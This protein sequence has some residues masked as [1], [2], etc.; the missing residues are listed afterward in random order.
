V[1]IACIHQGYE[2]YGSDRCFA[3]SVAGLRAAY[4]D[5]E[6]EVVLP[7]TGPIVEVLRNSA[8]RISFEPLWVLRRQSLWKLATVGAARLPIAIARAARRFAASDLVYINTSVVADYILAARFFRHK[9]LLHVHEIPE[10]AAR[11]VLRAMVL[12]SGAEVIFNSQATRAAFALPKDRLTHVVYNGIAGPPAPEL[13]TYDGLRPLRLLM[14]GRISRI[15]GQD[16]LLDAL[17]A[18]PGPVR[19]RVQ[20]R[21]VGSAFENLARERALAGRIDDMKPSAD[22]SLES[23]RADPAPLYRWADVVVVP[24][25]RSEALGR[26][27]IE[28]MAYGRPPIVSAIG[29]L[30]EV[31]E[32]ERSGWLVPPGDA[33]ALAAKLTRI[34]GDPA[35]WRSFSAAGRA[36]YEAL[37]ES[38][39]AMA[40]ICAITDVKLGRIRG[41]SSAA[42]PLAPADISADLK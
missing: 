36:R 10:P 6:I 13:V 22:V 32:D 25:C 31:V 38:A 28:A 33:S 39:P 18:L 2:L 17:A 23:F 42:Q 4:P 1:R 20:L 24:S 14:L 9:A 11:A 41:M 40:A 35:A 7:R 16:V 5:A 30:T 29:G 8:T 37:F 15:K 26:V 3:E 19:N 21:I 12:W 27:A 34:I